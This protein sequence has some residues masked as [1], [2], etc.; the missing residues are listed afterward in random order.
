MTKSKLSKSVAI[1]TLFYLS[2][3]MVWFGLQSPARVYLMIERLP[4]AARSA[5]GDLPD[6]SE[7]TILDQGPLQGRMVSAWSV[8]VAT[9]WAVALIAGMVSATVGFFMMELWAARHIKAHLVGRGLIVGVKRHRGGFR[10]LKPSMGEMPTPRVLPRAKSQVRITG[11]SFT[12]E[13]LALWDAIFDTL[14]FDPDAFAGDGHGV[15][16]FQHTINVC[17]KM[18]EGDDV[19]AQRMLVAAGHDIGKLACVRKRADGRRYFERGHAQ[20]SAQLIA[21]MPEFMALPE[22]EGAE[23]RLAIKYEHN[24]W[25]LPYV[26][27]ANTA[28]IS[29]MIQA[30]RRVDG[31]VT[32]EEKRAVAAAA[33]PDDQR[34]TYAFELFTK[35]MPT[36]PI[37]SHENTGD[38]ANV[39]FKRR[40]RLFIL[41]SGL[42][43]FLETEM[44]PEMYAA[45][46]M[47]HRVTGQVHP[48]IRNLMLGFDKEGWLLKKTK[49]QLADGT[50]EEIEVEAEKA[51]WDIQSG[52]KAFYGV[53][54]VDVPA[55]FMSKLTPENTKFNIKISGIHRP[56]NEPYVMELP[57]TSVTDEQKKSFFL[58]E[59]K[60]PAPASKGSKR[61][62]NTT[63][64]APLPMT[65]GAEQ[66]VPSLPGLAANGSDEAKVKGVPKKVGGLSRKSVNTAELVSRQASLFSK[67]PATQKKDSGLRAGSIGVP[68]GIKGVTASA[69]PGSAEK[70]PGDAPA[71]RETQ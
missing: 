34:P 18:L 30:L 63:T 31:T 29:D 13:Q 19:T 50:T 12:K 35:I 67:E 40:Q 41:E 33:I 55:H 26:P 37:R 42:R 2:L 64:S 32:A 23:I 62:D 51:I 68:K 39:A 1:L 56:R 5:A 24:R 38:R 8:P 69:I 61:I 36:M 57:V 46:N 6:K 3:G 60:R 22:A 59:E 53:I 21:A 44:P 7:I 14:S 28:R 11:V 65:Q 17:E 49:V 71:T 47:E 16:L 20:A 54:V 66:V 10:N 52:T 27:G 70:G 48:F 43:S 58:Q 25:E 9:L 4:A 45:L 15:G